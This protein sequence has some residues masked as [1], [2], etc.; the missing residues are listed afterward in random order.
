[1][2]RVT[3][4]GVILTLLFIIAILCAAILAL[5]KVITWDN[6]SVFLAS[7][8]SMRVGYWLGGLKGV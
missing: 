8:I 2:S 3:P 7:L 5:T 6:F 4:S 1:M